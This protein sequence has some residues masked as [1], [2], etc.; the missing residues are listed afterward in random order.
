MGWGRYFLLGDFGQQLDLNDLKSRVERLHGSLAGGRNV[1]TA[2]N[3]RL[4]ELELQM[5]HLTAGFAALTELL[6]KKGIVSREELAAA[7]DAQV[8]AAERAAA[9]RSAAAAEEAKQTQAALARRRAER[10]KS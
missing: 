1:D 5:L 4:D 3:R 9:E 7:I 8:T 2:Q 10:R 6:T